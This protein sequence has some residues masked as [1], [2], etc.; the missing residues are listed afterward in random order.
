MGFFGEQNSTLKNELHI[1]WQDFRQKTK[2]TI[3]FLLHLKQS[4]IQLQSTPMTCNIVITSFQLVKGIFGELLDV[5]LGS[6]KVIMQQTPQLGPLETLSL[7]QSVCFK[8]RI[9]DVIKN[10]Q[11]FQFH[12]HSWTIE[13]QPLF[14]SSTLQSRLLLICMKSF[15]YYLFQI[16]T[17]RRL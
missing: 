8:S 15:L 3:I 9:N 7:A 12:V 2:Q 1:I 4:K 10:H 17:N 11:Y 16:S 13:F 6:K 5:I 14:S